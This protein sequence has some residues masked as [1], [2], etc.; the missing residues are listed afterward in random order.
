MS[1]R[2]R[3]WPALL[4]LPPSSLDPGPAAVLVLPVREL[5]QPQAILTRV[6]R[7][8][9]GTGLSARNPAVR[10]LCAST[11]GR[12]WLDPLAADVERC[13][14]RPHPPGFACAHGHF[15]PLSQAA[16]PGQFTQILDGREG[17]A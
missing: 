8:L 16:D 2:S 3:P 12:K 1:W 14:D 10:G 11:A 17:N 13:R 5:T 9:V 6:L 15:Q 4:A 7:Q